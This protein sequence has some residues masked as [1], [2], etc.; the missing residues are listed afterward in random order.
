MAARVGQRAE[1]QGHGVGL[2]TAEVEP[3][4]VPSLRPQNPMGAGDQTSKAGRADALW[5]QSM[6]QAE[7]GQSERSGELIAG[8]GIEKAPGGCG[9]IPREDGGCGTG[10]A[11]RGRERAEG[12]LAGTLVMIRRLSQCPLSPDECGIVAQISEP[13]AAADIPAYYISTFK[14]DHAL[15]SVLHWP[16]GRGAGF[17]GSRVCCPLPFQV[18]E[19]NISGVINALKVS[20]AE[21]H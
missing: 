2:V 1:D 9:G 21:K 18:P 11:G 8:E 19:E 5:L 17:R 16:R 13:L 7:G 3:G 12:A 4:V 10:S 15:V 14:F 20:Q 6:E